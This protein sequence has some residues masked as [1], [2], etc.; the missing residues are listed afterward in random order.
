MPVINSNMG[1]LYG[2]MH[3]SRTESMLDEAT[4]R[5]SSGKKL[6]S[7]ADDAAGMAISTRM[8]A[9]VRGLNMAVKNAGDGISM[10]NSIE[11]ALDEVTNMLLRMRE[12]SVQA[13]ND[14]NFGTDRIY[15]NEEINQLKNE[16]SRISANTRFNGE[17]VLDGSLTSKVFQLGT[18]GGETVSFAVDSVSSSALGAFTYTGTTKEAAAAA[19]T[20]TANTNTTAEDVSV[21]GHTVSKDFAASAAQS[22]KSLAAAINVETGATGVKATAQTYAKLLSTAAS[23]TYSITLNGTSTGNFA[24]GSTSVG[25]AVTKINQISGTTGVTAAASSDGSFVTLHHAQGEDI[26]I[27]NDSAGTDLDVVAVGYDGKTAGATVI[28]LAATAGNDST[29]VQ[30][31]VQLSSSKTFSVTQSGTAALGYFVTGSGSLSTISNVD[32]KS[33]AAATAAISTIDGAMEKISSVRAELGALTNRLEYTVDNLTN[34]ATNTQAAISRIVD[35]DFAA[36]TAKLTK[37]QILQQAGTAM[38]AQAN[39]S[40]QSVLALLGQ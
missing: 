4:M 11:G 3:L 40:K 38:L 20:V 21:H 12:L 2:Q 29:S 5:L 16:I 37:A 22:G 19:A 27:I 1:S 24:I 30:G 13:V 14:T 6:N 35:A 31:N 25:D 18:E 8:N 9:Q 17:P 23:A 26:T 10:L 28:S 7:S 33:Q 15:L 36:E 34:I 39:Q 32:V